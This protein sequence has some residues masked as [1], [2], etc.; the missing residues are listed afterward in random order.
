MEILHRIEEADP[1]DDVPCL[2][3]DATLTFGKPY[4][5]YRYNI[6][7]CPGYDLAKAEEEAFRATGR[8]AIG[9]LA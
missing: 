2:W 4:H 5:E 1:R 6:H 7:E 8:L 9:E 3:C